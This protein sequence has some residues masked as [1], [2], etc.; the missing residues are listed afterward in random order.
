MKLEG[1]EAFLLLDVR[2]P[3]EVAIAR[4]AGSMLIPVGDLPNRLGE[5]DGWRD[6]EIV[7]HCKTGGRSRKACGILLKSGFSNVKNLYGGIEEWAS[8]VDPSVPRY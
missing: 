2:E 1:K 7:V 4:I 6:R 3:N 5:I 8:Q